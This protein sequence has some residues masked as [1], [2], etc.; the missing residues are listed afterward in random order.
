MNSINIDGNTIRF[1]IRRRNVKYPRLEFSENILTLIIPKNRK[2]WRELIKQ[3]KNWILSKYK[4]L[5][6]IIDENGYLSKEFI[7]FGKKVKVEVSNDK[8]KIGKKIVG[9]SFLDINKKLKGV[10]SKKISKI[11]D[12]YSKKLGVKYNKILIR[13][14]KTKWSSCSTRGNLT[15]NIKAISLPEDLL[16]YLVY[17]EVLH[18]LERNHSIRFIKLLEKEFPNFREKEEELKRYWI[19]LNENFWW[20]KI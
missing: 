15:F 3:K 16:R 14:Q 17:H 7:F 11:A 2:K 5:K 20:K 12:E 19:I 6:K 18:F 4:E 9:R 1:V 8:V 10:L 13:R